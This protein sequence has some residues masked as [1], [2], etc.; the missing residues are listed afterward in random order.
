MEDVGLGYSAVSVDDGRLVTLGHDVDAGTDVVHCLDAET[1]ESLWTCAFPAGL[2][3]LGHEG[4]TTAT[5][6]FDGDRVY[7]KNRWGLLLCLSAEDGT[8]IWGRDLVKSQGATMGR[9]GFASAPVIVGDLVVIDAGIAYAFDR[10]SGDLVW[11]TRDYRQGYATPV[12]FTRGE[13]GLIA[14]MNATGLV[15]VDAAD[16]AE[17]A[18]H[19]WPTFNDINASSPIIVDDQRIFISSGANHGCAMLRFDGEMLGVEWESKVLKTAMNAAVLHDGFLYGFDDRE[20][21]CIDLEGNERWSHRGL[22]LGSL[23]IAGDRLVVLS[24]KGRLLVAPASPDAFTPEADI[25]AVA[26]EGVCWTMPVLV[27]GLV[28]LRSSHGELVCRDHRD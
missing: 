19:D 18:V 14:L 13:R 27:N 5:P 9:W 12:A 24:D 3:D 4:G 8:L 23:I 7:A 21:K 28:Y 6:I 20:L 11:R 10:Q 15:I 1:G 16:G 26:T 2:L 17:V 22:G 25:D